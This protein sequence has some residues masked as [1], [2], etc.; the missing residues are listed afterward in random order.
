M[1][2]KNSYNRYPI[3]CTWVWGMGCILWVQIVIC[4]QPFATA[5]FYVMSCYIGLQIMSLDC[6]TVSYVI[7]RLWHS[8]LP[9]GCKY[10]ASLS[11]SWILLYDNVFI[12]WNQSSPCKQTSIGSELS[13]YW[14]YWSRAPPHNR[15][16][17][18]TRLIYMS[19]S[20]FRHFHEH[21]DTKYSKP[22][23]SFSLKVLTL[24]QLGI[25]FKM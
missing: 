12:L 1:F 9:H 6:I 4:V 13:W 22:T 17:L 7:Y 10:D 5:V 3:A 16:I 18:V 11:W 8:F 2:S 21:Q 20:L 24:K 19:T 15:L 25:F 14:Q 23:A